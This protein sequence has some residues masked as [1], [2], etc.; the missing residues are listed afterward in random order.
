MRA[1]NE[2]YV[3]RGTYRWTAAS[4][5]AAGRTKQAR[6]VMQEGLPKMPNFR[7]RELVR[8]HPYQDAALR[9]TYGEHLLAA[10]YPA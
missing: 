1:M 4:L 10:G 5:A 2:R 6:D 3:M 9:R 7:V 8:L